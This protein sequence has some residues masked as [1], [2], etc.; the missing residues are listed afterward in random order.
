MGGRAWFSPCHSLMVQLRS[1]S[2]HRLPCSQ[3][4]RGSGHTGLTLISK[5]EQAEACGSTWH[6]PSTARVRPGR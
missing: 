5:P 3:P 6:M 1:H 2:L 4:Q